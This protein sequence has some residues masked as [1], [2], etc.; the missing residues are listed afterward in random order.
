MSM[1]IEN[2]VHSKL[3]VPEEAMKAV[4]KSEYSANLCNPYTIEELYVVWSSKTLANWKALVATTRPNDGMYFEVTRN[5][6]YSEIY[7]DTYI[8]IKNET[9]KEKL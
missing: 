9:Q 8:K 3:N 5:G 1:I 4:L 7:I 6:A 2:V